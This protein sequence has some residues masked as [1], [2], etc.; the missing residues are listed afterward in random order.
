MLFLSLTRP[1][2]IQN[3][4]NKGFGIELRLDLF[5][6][7]DIEY[8]KSFLNHFC[9]LCKVLKRP[10]GNRMIPRTHHIKFARPQVNILV[11]L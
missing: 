6:Q 9:F 1:K 2:S 7:I 8:V 5:P 11:E 3:I 10:F 4:Q